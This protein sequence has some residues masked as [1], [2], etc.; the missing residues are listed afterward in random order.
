[1]R[2]SVYRATGDALRWSTPRYEV[3][4]SRRCGTALGLPT[5]GAHLY[6]QDASPC[7]GAGPMRLHARRPP[8]PA[9]STSCAEVEL[10]SNVEVIF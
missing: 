6:S 1:M 4:C 8:L 5:C 3:S 9:G 10:L 2:A 7:P